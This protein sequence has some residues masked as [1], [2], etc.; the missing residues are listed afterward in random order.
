M[1]L[2][3]LQHGDINMQLLVCV[4]PIGPY[5][6]GDVLMI[7][8]TFDPAVLTSLCCC[9]IQTDTLLLSVQEALMHQ[10][11]FTMTLVTNRKFRFNMVALGIATIESPQVVITIPSATLL[12]NIIQ[13]F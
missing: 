1:V 6:P 10:P 9:V 8:P 2:F 11:L 7:T 3:W 13:V 12:A 5:N 4:N